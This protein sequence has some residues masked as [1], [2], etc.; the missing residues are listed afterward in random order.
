MNIPEKQVLISQFMQRQVLPDLFRFKPQDTAIGVD[1]RIHDHV[2][3][4]LQLRNI[5]GYLV[6][7]V[8]ITLERKHSQQTI[9]E[10]QSFEKSDFRIAVTL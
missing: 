8:D 6:P 9:V 4:D 5:P 1:Q 3:P 7:S 10:C 2:D